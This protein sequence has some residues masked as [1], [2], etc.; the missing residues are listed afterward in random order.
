VDGPVYDLA[1]TMSKFLLL[2]MPL[3]DVVARVTAN[4]AAL[5]PNQS[6]SAPHRGTSRLGTLGVGDGGDAVVFGLEEGSFDFFD[7]HGGCRTGN[8]RIT[9]AHVIK[10]GRLY[11]E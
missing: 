11:G 6:G 5:L 3:Q 9:P 1:A 2:G 10:D 4:P 7:A 8:L